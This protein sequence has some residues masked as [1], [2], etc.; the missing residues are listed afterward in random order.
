MTSTGARRQP[1]IIHITTADFDRPSICNEK[2]D[3]A[4]KVR[5]G[6][7]HDP[8]FL[9]VIYEADRDDDWTNPEVWAKAN[10]N[11]GISV[12]LQYLERE[13]RRAQETPSYEN[14]FK[15]LHLNMKTQQ[16]VRWLGMEAWDACGEE[17]IEESVLE[18]QECFAGLDLSTTTDI[19]AFVLAFQDE[20]GVLTVLPRFWIP[21]DSALKRERRDRVPYVDWARQ[22]LIETTPGNVIDY[23]RIRTHIND[24]KDRFKITEIAIDRWNATQLATQLQGDG[25]EV[26]AFGQ[27]FKDMTAPTKEL[28]KLVMS[29]KL[30]H[31]GHPVLRWM[32]SNVAVETDAAGNLKPSKKKSTERIDGIVALVMAL[33]RL[34]VTPI[35]TSVY[36]TRGLRWV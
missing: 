8:A 23:D 9:P 21:E 29:G 10:P 17:A 7:I 3:Y 11:L 13:C 12:S 14:T 1:L 32:A 31:A 34:M 27:G 16:D 19:S 5:D 28:E 18:G 26:V 22:G 33:G 35:E 20:E 2:Y 30:R 15:R 36:N 25:F 24:I 6:I 4:C